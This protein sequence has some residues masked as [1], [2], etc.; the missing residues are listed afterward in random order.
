MG[1]TPLR[2]RARQAPHLFGEVS[3]GRVA[4]LPV[5]GEEG[6]RHVLARHVAQRLRILGDRACTYRIAPTIV[7][8][9]G[10]IGLGD[11]FPLR[12]AYAD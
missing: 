8:K 3:D 7:N 1:G 6:S 11:P 2:C 9:Q 10:T 12:F 4:Q 5:F